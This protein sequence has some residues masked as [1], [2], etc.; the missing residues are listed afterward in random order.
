[1]EDGSLPSP[2][3]DCHGQPQGQEDHHSPSQPKR[4]HRTA[5]GTGHSPRSSAPRWRP[6]TPQGASRFEHKMENSK[7]DKICSTLCAMLLAVGQVSYW[8]LD[9]ILKFLTGS[10]A[11]TRLE[12]NQ[13]LQR[14][15]N[16]EALGL[17]GEQL[18]AFSHSEKGSVPS[19]EKGSTHS[20]GTVSN[21]N[22]GHVSLRLD[23]SRSS[24]HSQS[25]HSPDGQDKEVEIEGLLFRVPC[26]DS[27]PSTTASSRASGCPSLSAP[28]DEE[29]EE[30]GQSSLDRNHTGGTRADLEMGM[31]EKCERPRL[32]RATEAT[33]KAMEETDLN[34]A[35]MEG[36]LQSMRQ[37]P[38]TV[39]TESEKENDSE[40]RA[41]L[42][43]SRRAGRRRPLVNRTLLFSAPILL[44]LLC[45][46]MLCSTMTSASSESETTDFDLDRREYDP[47]MLQRVNFTA[48][49]CSKSANDD[50]K[51]LDLT[52]VADCPSADHDYL[53]P[54]DRPIALVMSH[55]PVPT[56]IVRCDMKISKTLYEHEGRMHEAATRTRTLY[57][58]KR[59]SVYGDLCRAMFAVRSWICP[60]NVCGGR[61]SSP[62]NLKVGQEVTHTWITRGEY[63][64]GY[65]YPVTYEHENDNGVTVQLTGIE[66]TELNIKIQSYSA[67]LDLET[68]R[69]WSEQIKFQSMYELPGSA[70]TLDDYGTITW[71]HQKWK[72]GQQL[73]LITQTSATVRKLV[74]EKRPGNTKVQ[75]SEYSGA[76]LIIKN[77]TE[78]RASGLILSEN[79]HPCFDSCFA[80]NVPKLLICI[81]P[82][83]VGE[84]DRVESRPASLATAS[85]INAQAMS[86]Y[87]ELSS[88]LDLY[89]LH[90]RL[91]EK[92]CDIDIRTIKQDFAFLMNAK[93]QYALQGLSTGSTEYPTL[94]GNGT[95]FT[96]LVRGSTAYFTQCKSENVQVVALPRC[97]LQIP[98]VR[99]NGMLSWADA[100]NHHIIDYP[101]WVDCDSGLPVQYRIND[102]YYCHTTNSHRT[103]PQGTEPVVLRPTV[104]AVRGV[105]VEDIPVLGGL[106]LTDRQLQQIAKMQT[107]HEL[108]SI[109]LDDIKHKVMENTRSSDEGS[110]GIYFATSLTELD[111][112]V[113]SYTV[114]TQ[115]FFL[116]RFLGETYLNLFGIFML[117]SLSKHLIDTAFRIFA[118]VRIHGV[119]WWIFRALWHSLYATTVLPQLILQKAHQ[120]MDDRMQ[121]ARDAVFPDEIRQVREDNE[122]MKAQIKEIREIHQLSHSS[123]SAATAWTTIA[124][125]TPSLRKRTGAHFR[126]LETQEGQN[127]QEGGEE[128]NSSDSSSY[129][130]RGGA[131]WRRRRIRNELMTAHH[132]DCA[133]RHGEE[134]DCHFRCGRCGKPR[135]F[136]TE[137]RECQQCPHSEDESSSNSTLRENDERQQ[138][139]PP[140]C[141]ARDNQSGVN[142]L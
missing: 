125:T 87:L 45:S 134:T 78:N 42:K 120:A 108:G 37:E 47:G 123:A 140:D 20:H 107:D 97:S 119:G 62:I 43:E 41:S 142:Q 40:I 21:F 66:E 103:C 124:Q 127:A 38:C 44:S 10:W 137:N 70:V 17:L 65:P 24:L 36:V 48:F 4:R 50:W 128:N 27:P 61:T 69:I 95:A 39:H 93:S 133:Y 90:R 54:E 111:F 112:Q 2:S 131:H 57:S 60:A 98:I 68:R 64:K 6:R 74:A 96:V 117:V 53:D 101:T 23:Q 46:M 22:I 16:P 33:Q 130:P 89:S 25:R 135:S 139:E 30:D 73:A 106:T 35:L 1:M 7:L 28:S 52:Q 114:A 15:V 94:G 83:V 110:R 3:A 86:T 141:P 75:Y 76:M 58:K 84:L 11:D 85:R 56:T 55:V 51:G 100:V 99:D 18:R 118:I 79:R 115:M 29:S 88:S 49:D 32:C 77:V 104:G 9:E 31:G 26:E 12:M 122:L 8:G 105:K 5:E 116:F 13:E 138:A 71:E 126:R 34:L 80:T 136:A 82:G 113:I 59:L 121:E 81:D 14:K 129:G 91:Q 72:C 19:P 102:R 132:P 92:I 63:V 67:L 109:I